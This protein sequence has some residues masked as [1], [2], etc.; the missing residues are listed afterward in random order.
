MLEQ[1]EGWIKELEKEGFSNVR[2]VPIAP[3]FEAGEHTHPDHTVHIIL[4]GELTI[5]DEEGSKTFRTGDRVEFKAG[6]TH[7]AKGGVTE[8]SMIVGTKRS[9]EAA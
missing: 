9:Y 4:S 1:A 7:K 5:T 3:G 2:V 8:G 6:T